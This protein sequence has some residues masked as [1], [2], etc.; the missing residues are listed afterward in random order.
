MCVL[1]R[2]RLVVWVSAVLLFF[3]VCD[4]QLH[5]EAQSGKLV[6]ARGNH[7]AVGHLMGKKSVDET[8]SSDDRDLDA[9]AYL[10]RAEADTHTQPSRLLKALVKVLSGS[11]RDT[12]DER[13]RW[14]RSME[15]KTRPE[16]QLERQ[17]GVNQAARFFLLAL[18][19]R[20]SDTS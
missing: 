17:R 4:A 11:K 10:I 3:L 20:D 16:E 8:T 12:E 18:N 14:E 6:F 2:Y 9:Q 7:W 19:T 5:N 13:E 15:L 1:W